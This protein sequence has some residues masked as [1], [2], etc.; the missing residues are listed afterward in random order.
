[1][2]KG[3]I[4]LALVI[5]ACVATYGYRR[6]Q[7]SLLSPFIMGT[8][9]AGMRFS[10]VDDEARREMKHGFTC[11]AAGDG[12]RICELTTDTPI[13]QL[14]IVVDRSGRAAVIQLL[15]TEKSVGWSNAGSATIAQWSHVQE[16]D[17]EPSDSQ[18]DYNHGRWQTPDSLWSAEVLWHRTTNVPTEMLVVDERRVRRI[19]ESSPT[20]I[21]TLA[22]EKILHGRSLTMVENL[23]ANAAVKASSMTN[24]RAITNAEKVAQ[25]VRSLPQCSPAFTPVSVRGNGTDTGMDAT[26]RR[27]AEQTIAEAYPGQRL[28]IGDHAMYLAD[29]A[30]Q[31]EEVTLY[32]NAEGA[33]GKMY[34]F[35]VTFPRRVEAAT[36]HAKNFDTRSQCRANSEVLLATV[37]PVTGEIDGIQRAQPDDESLISEIGA[38]DFAPTADAPPRLIAIFSAVYAT[39]E[40]YGLVRWNELIYADSLRVARRSPIIATKTLVDGTQSGGPLMPQDESEDISGLSYTPGD[41]LRFS[42]AVTA[43]VSPLRQI[44]LPTG[45]RVLPS[46]WSLLGQ[47]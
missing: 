26:L 14:K 13:G 11:R 43:V 36:A 38:L 37:D 35:A 10:D 25:S 2:S 21:F 19:A 44:A 39:K 28:V 27:V 45:D 24:P 22:S 12:V 34:A 40:W 18:S 33:D 47:L 4:L 17:V 41:T 8:T 31:L 7:R 16:S 15:S 9:R 20:T 29:A 42:T 6:Y 32:P 5:V 23:A 46:G 30:G 3:R 1:M